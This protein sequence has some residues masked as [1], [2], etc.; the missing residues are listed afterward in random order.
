MSAEICTNVRQAAR[1]LS[2]G[3]LLRDGE[4]KERGNTGPM[5][6]AGNVCVDP[7]FCQDELAWRVT[8][9][10]SK[11]KSRQRK[12][13][14]PPVCAT[15]NYRSWIPAVPTFLH[16]TFWGRRRPLGRMTTRS[17]NVVA[18]ACSE[19]LRGRRCVCR[20]LVCAHP[21][22]AARMHTKAAKEAIVRARICR[23][24]PSFRTLAPPPSSRY[25]HTGNLV[26]HSRHC[27]LHHRV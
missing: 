18:G 26:R 11:D 23:R 27:P 1:G 10:T 13:G 20:R 12:A 3:L 15:R 9:G 8:C 14:A 16:V 17:P 2:D 6:G 19:R 24:C 21:H 5:V 4:K 22:K 25:S 7:V